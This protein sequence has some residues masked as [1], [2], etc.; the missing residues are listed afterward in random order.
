MTTYSYVWAVGYAED[1]LARYLARVDDGVANEDDVDH[2][3]IALA[4]LR[5]AK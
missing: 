3:R 5:D 2:L 4:H 1:V